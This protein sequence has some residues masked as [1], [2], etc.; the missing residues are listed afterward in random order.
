MLH[1]IFYG[2]GTFG[3]KITTNTDRQWYADLLG[4]TDVKRRRTITMLKCN[5]GAQLN[6]AS[7]Y[8]TP[9][10]NLGIFNL[11]YQFGR[12]DPFPGGISYTIDENKDVTVYGYGS[13]NNYQTAGFTIGNS[14]IPATSFDSNAKL[15]LDYTITHPEIFIYGNTW[16]NSSTLRS[17]PWMISRCLWGDNNTANRSVNNGGLDPEPWGTAEEKGKKTIYDPCPSGWRVAAADSWSGIAN[18]S[19]SASWI[20]IGNYVFKDDFNKGYILYFNSKTSGISTYIPAT[21]RRGYATGKLEAMGHQGGIWWSSPSGSN[22]YSGTYF[23]AINSS[24]G[25]H[26]AS[27][28]NQA[29]GFPIRCVKIEP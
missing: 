10:G 23:Y 17:V 29:I 26:I 5:I 20:N 21:G 27:D 4:R 14:L 1:A 18:E 11:Q 15:I 28:Y 13:S 16:L 6:D 19:M 25:I 8:N 9:E 7:G 2:V 12:K 24:N 22:T 3:M